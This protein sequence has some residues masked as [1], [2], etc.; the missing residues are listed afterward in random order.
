[1]LNAKENNMGQHDNTVT[2]EELEELKE[3]FQARLGAADR[4]IATL[5][6]APH[7]ALVCAETTC[8]QQLF[9]VVQHTPLSASMHTAQQHPG[10]SNVLTECARHHCM[11][12]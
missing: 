12:S 9:L 6:V 4:T 5:Q 7:R 11:L 10:L 3:E 8:F 1:M 2:E